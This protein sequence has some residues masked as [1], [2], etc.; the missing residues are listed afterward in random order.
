MLALVVIGLTWNALPA[1]ED[2]LAQAESAFHMA[3]G[4][5][6]R[7]A[8]ARSFRQAA[9]LYEQ[10]YA[11]GVANAA[12]LANAGQAHLL[13]GD[14]PRAVLAFRR[15]LRYRPND[16]PL[17]RGLELARSQVFRSTADVN[18]R[19]QW[20]Q[21]SWQGLVAGALSSYVLVLAL[22]TRW[23]MTRQTV[24]LFLAAILLPLGAILA[25]LSYGATIGVYEIQEP[26]CV[27]VRD[28]VIL[29]T[30][31]GQSYPPRQ[32]AP[33]HRGV[34]VRLMHERGDWLQVQRADGAVGWI[35]RAG[36][37]FD[38]AEFRR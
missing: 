7:A 22:G 23:L 31:N 20:P 34:E 27:I 9:D 12:L 4:T 8:A 38:D 18:H 35:P 1:E 3:V 25:V 5:S 30:G 37:L 11:S 16:T 19:R 32:E 14:V 29:R 10:L 36:A 17:L 13:A 21:W 28:G 15:G 33:L 24:L 6:D 26:I 2:V